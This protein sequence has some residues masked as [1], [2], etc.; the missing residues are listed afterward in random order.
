MEYF[1]INHLLKKNS[2]AICCALLKHDYSNFAITILEYC[3]PDKCLIREKHYCSEI[4]EIFEIFAG[5]LFFGKENVLFLV[6]Q[7]Y[8]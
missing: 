4:F 5:W 8:R 7:I 3:E 1:N 6:N 2:M